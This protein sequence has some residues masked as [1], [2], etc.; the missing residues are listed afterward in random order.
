MGSGFK[1]LGFRVSGFGVL[2]LPVAEKTYLLRSY[3]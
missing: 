3:I 1:N 2:S